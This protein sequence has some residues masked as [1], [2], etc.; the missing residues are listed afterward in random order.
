VLQKPFRLNRLNEKI[1][2]LLSDFLL[3]ALRQ[4][5]GRPASEGL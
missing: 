5:P 2:D 3:D 1:H 4:S